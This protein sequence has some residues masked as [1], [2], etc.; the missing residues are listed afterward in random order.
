MIPATPASTET[1][2]NVEGV[3]KDKEDGHLPGD[4][5]EGGER[6]GVGGHAEVLAVKKSVRMSAQDDSQMP[7]EEMTDAIGWKPQICQDETWR[8]ESA[9]GGRH[10]ANR[11]RDREIMSDLP[12]SRSV[13]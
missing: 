5:G 6:Y 10:D 12:T 4:G 1:C 13:L 2:A 9:R 11:G 7:G 8:M 3:L